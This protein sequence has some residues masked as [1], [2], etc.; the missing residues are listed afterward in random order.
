MIRKLGLALLALALFSIP[1]HAQEP[2]LAITINSSASSPHSCGRVSYPLYCYGIPISV[3]GT[4]GT[5]WL[6][7][8]YQTNTGFALFNVQNPAGT[9]VFL[10]T[11]N[12]TG[13]NL[14]YGAVTYGTHTSLQIISAQVG[15]TFIG[16]PDGDGDNDSS[17]AVM[18]LNF[19]YSYGCSSGRGGGCFWIQQA[20]DGSIITAPALN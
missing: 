11:A 9:Y 12:I 16:D 17:T 1:I 19:A 10:S 14:T 3:N 5:M 6:D 15:L 7:A 4:P 20:T 8:Y 18:T 2:P 13:V